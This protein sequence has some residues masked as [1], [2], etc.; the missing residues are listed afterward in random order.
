ML[1]AYVG[2]GRGRT[3]ITQMNGQW[4]CPTTNGVVWRGDSRR[5]TGNGIALL[6]TALFGGRIHAEER[7]ME[8]PYYER[9]CLAGGVSGSEKTEGGRQKAE[10]GKRNAEGR[11][12]KMAGLRLLPLRCGKSKMAILVG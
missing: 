10:G 7:A 1:R 2:G 5:G 6:R 12:R 11:R 4:N 8:L 3:G 9:R